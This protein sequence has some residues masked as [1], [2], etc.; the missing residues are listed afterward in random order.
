MGKVTRSHISMWNCRMVACR[1][2]LGRS[3]V[4]EV[5]SPQCFFPPC[6]A[7]TSA[8][9]C[10]RE[11]HCHE[12]LGDLRISNHVRALSGMLYIDGCVCVVRSVACFF[13]SRMKYVI[14]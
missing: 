5:V 2:A 12:I 8:Q 13:L 3:P 1:S 7:A 14:R 11:L 9:H 4:L 6:A 10:Y